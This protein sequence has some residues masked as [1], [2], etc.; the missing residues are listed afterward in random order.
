MNLYPKSTQGTINEQLGFSSDEDVVHADLSAMALS[1][2][3][4]EKQRRNKSHNQRQPGGQRRRDPDDFVSKDYNNF[5]LEP[6]VIP[7]A[8]Q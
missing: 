5:M 2:D 4:I 6:W 1:E 7:D 8:S 3:P